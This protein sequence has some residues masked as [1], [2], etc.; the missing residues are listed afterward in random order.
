MMQK[1]VLPSQSASRLKGNAAMDY[2]KS[3]S[4]SQKQ[5]PKTSASNSSKGRVRLLPAMLVIGVGI[6]SF[7]V[8]DVSEDVQVSTDGLK[9]KSSFAQQSAQA[10][11][12]ANAANTADAAPVGLPAQLK[13][14]QQESGELSVA[15]DSQKSEEEKAKLSDFLAN[16]GDL[17]KAEINLLRGLSKRREE[18]DMLEKRLEERSDMLSAAEKRVDEK[19]SEL[20]TLQA[21]IE[22]LLVQHNEQEQKQLRSLVKIYEVMKPK[23]AAKVFEQLEMPILLDVIER[24][25]ER[26]AAPILAQMSPGRAKE[27]TVELAQRRQLPI[28]KQ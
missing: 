28:P 1:T 18:L 5:A 19:V 16:S 7:K 2:R 21:T 4:G 11:T 17:T 20:Q 10:A 24:M 22:S 13:K 26:L 14:T 23:D 15:E 25:K 6:L 8:L 9:I 27:V 3:V 12:E